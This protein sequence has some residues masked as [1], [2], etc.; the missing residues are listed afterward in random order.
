MFRFQYLSTY[1]QVP[2]F[3][4]RF[5][6]SNSIAKYEISFPHLNHIILFAAIGYGQIASVI[7]PRHLFLSRVNLN[8]A[9]CYCL[10]TFMNYSRVFIFIF[11]MSWSCLTAYDR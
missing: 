5:V 10:I 1:F 9:F 2:I 8:V 11:C 6:A 3:F 4:S 7:H